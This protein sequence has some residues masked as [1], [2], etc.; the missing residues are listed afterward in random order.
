MVPII[1]NGEDKLIYII[2]QNDNWDCSTI[3][4]ISVN[5]FPI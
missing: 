1:P 3:T 4:S 2:G 5:G